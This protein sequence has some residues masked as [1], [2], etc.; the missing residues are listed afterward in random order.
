MKRALVFALSL[1]TV[2]S[3]AHAQSG[4]FVATLGADTVHVER[5]M[6][7]GNTLEGTIVTRT[8]ETR[9]ATY[10]MTFG[11]D[12]K[13]THYEV[14]TTDG[15]GKPLATSGAAA[16]LDY[17]GDSIVRRTLDK[18]Q[19]TTQVIPAPTG[20]FPSPSIPYIGVSYLM[21]EE[22]F[23]AAR[24][25]GGAQPDSAIYLITMLAAQPR[26]SRNKI[27]FVGVD[28]AEMNYFDVSRSGYRFDADGHLVRADWT[29][30][31]YR[32]RI[33]RV[34]DVDVERVAQAWAAADRRGA[35]F[36]ALSPR[37]TSRGEVAGIAVA[38]DY[39]RPAQRGRNL[40]GDVVRLDSVW[41]L[42]ADM[43]THMTT[44]ADL[45]FGDV[46]V[47]AGRYTLWMLLTRDGTGQLIVNSRVNVFGT[48]YDRRADFARIPLT[49]TNGRA[50]VE[51][52]SILARDGAL[53]IAWGDVDWS[54]ALKPPS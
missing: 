21:Y 2:A 30:T 4:G 38:I 22:A 9:V 44:A 29:G 6:R 33:T 11:D 45:M 16:S 5:F 51:R 3:R 23:N 26:P 40:W 24:R 46:R 19:L 52:L 15:N 39:S 27:W 31:T 34:P 53:H 17:S 43:A 47:P 7:R 14:T 50:P 10:R 12:G 13:P 1:V 8:P 25:R 49:R 18:G 37:D 32:Y 36:G 28:S 42:G 48:Q 41:R 35:A 20:A 54:V